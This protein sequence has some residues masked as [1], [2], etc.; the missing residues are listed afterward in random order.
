MVYLYKLI[1][2]FFHKDIKSLI[3][4]NMY[5]EE[6]LFIF[7]LLFHYSALLSNNKGFVVDLQM[8]KFQYALFHKGY[9][10]CYSKNE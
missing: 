8:G 2:L 10:K 6:F 9:C 1:T 7:Q 4:S 3:I 5:M